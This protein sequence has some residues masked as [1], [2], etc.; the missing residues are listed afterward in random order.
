VKVEDAF[1]GVTSVL[2]DTAPAIY[3]LE[4]NLQFGPAMERFFQFRA[5]QGITLVTTPITLAEC[6][7]HPIKQGRK[8]LETAYQSLIV[9]GQGTLFWPIGADKGTAAAGFRAKYGLKLADAIQAAVG[10]QSRCQV[11]LT[12]DADLKKVAEIRV[13]LVSELEP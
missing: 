2:L 5:A 4:K 10:L 3:Y 1:R 11:L 9:T 13:A 8:D 12:N 7:M 6:V